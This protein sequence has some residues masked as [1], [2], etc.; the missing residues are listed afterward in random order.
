M[1]EAL[2][3]TPG[4]STAKI[5]VRV[6]GAGATHDL[7]RHLAALNTQRR[8]VRFTTGRTV[9]EADEQAIAKLPEEAW[10]TSL[11]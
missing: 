9:T 10:E 1:S 5:L 11:K 8:T 6:D 3:R 2:A 4:R 7:L